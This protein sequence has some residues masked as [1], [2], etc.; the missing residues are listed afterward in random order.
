MLSDADVD[1]VW[2]FAARAK[3]QLGQWPQDLVVREKKA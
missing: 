1:R 2:D 3:M